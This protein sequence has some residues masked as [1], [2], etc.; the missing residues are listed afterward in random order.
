MTLKG[1]K[2]VVDPAFG[3]YVADGG[4]G[5]P[6]VKEPGYKA[7]ATVPVAAGAATAGAAAQSH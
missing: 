7:P 4:Q 6:V 5:L 3:T 2:V 1:A